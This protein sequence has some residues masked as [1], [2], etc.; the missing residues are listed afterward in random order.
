MSIVK[1]VALIL[2]ILNILYPQVSTGGQP[3]S[4]IQELD[5]NFPN[6]SLPPIDYNMLIEEDEM[7]IDKHI[8]FRFG[9]PFEVIYNLEN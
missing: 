1:N 6:I 5:N 3:Q 9:A 4:L 2:L 7:Q 8:P